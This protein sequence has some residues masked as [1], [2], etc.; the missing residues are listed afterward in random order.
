M[1][2]VPAKNKF[3][4]D[5]AYFHRELK[6][7]NND[8]QYYRPDELARALVRLAFVANHETA[9]NTVAAEEQTQGCKRCRAV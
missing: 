2:K 1:V 8:L 5:C 3:G 4:L 6:R 9:V 7:V